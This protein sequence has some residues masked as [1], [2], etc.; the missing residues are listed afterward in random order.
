[1]QAFK[2]GEHFDY[3]NLGFSILSHL[4]GKL[5]QRHWTESVKQRIM[6]PLQMTASQMAIGDSTRE[7]EPSSYV[8]LFEDR[9]SLRHG[10]IVKIG[11]RSFEDAAG[12]IV[13]TPGD[14]AKY[15]RMLLNRG[16][17]PSRKNR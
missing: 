16:E 13:S 9:V 11:P 8:P 15:M 14:M 17:S 12:S 1:V 4:I 2:P 3:C 10:P 7:L 6:I 5:D